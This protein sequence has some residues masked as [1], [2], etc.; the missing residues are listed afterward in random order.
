MI[1]GEAPGRVSLE[2]GRPF[3]NPRAL[4]VRNA[5]ARAVAPMTIAPEDLLYFSDAVKCWPGSPT[6]ANRS[7]RATETIRCTSLHLTRELEIIHPRLIFAFGVRAASAALGYPIKI[8]D[9]HG[10]PLDHPHGYRVIP[11]M[12]PSTINIAGMRR[13]GMR[14]VEHYETALAELF[15]S[16]LNRLGL[17][18]R[19]PARPAA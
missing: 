13:V 2:H 14:N 17:I 9:Y 19:G 15:R 10:R 4:T 16:E 11:L 1:L 7:P 6:G 3:S 5:F 8:A 18:E 12:H